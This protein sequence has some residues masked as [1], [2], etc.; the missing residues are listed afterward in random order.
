MDSMSI[1]QEVEVSSSVD[2]LR[3]TLTTW[4]ER[5]GLVS[6]AFRQAEDSYYLEATLVGLL[7]GAAW[8][9]GH[10]T[11]TEVKIRR[12]DASG[13]DRGGR[14]DF[15]MHHGETR[16]AIEAKLIWDSEFIHRNVM[17]SVNTA[18]SEV[19]SISGDR[20][21]VL[22]GGVFFVP[23]WNTG[24]QKGKLGANTL[25]PFQELKTDIK[26]CFYDPA[27]DY[28]GV[29]LVAQIARQNLAFR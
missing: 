11:I 4:V 22:L 12:S 10:E 13:P 26:A 6:K 24:A 27:L 1:I 23:W 9:N 5:V 29:M 25:K 20:A 17:D 18:C 28:P 15:L 8:A 7:S 14:L 3:A 2:F 19:V 21:D 16:I